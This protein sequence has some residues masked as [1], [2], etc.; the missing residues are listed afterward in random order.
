MMRWGDVFMGAAG[1]G[2]Q[3]NMDW[4]ESG[5]AGLKYLSYYTDNG[6]YY[7][8]HTTQGTCGDRDGTPGHG[9]VKN[10]M[11]QGATGYVATLD[12]LSKYFN[13]AV[14]AAAGHSR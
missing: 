4:T 10:T 5:D 11:P 1:A 13:E 8:Y 2:K 7:Y 14:S 9:C 12:A 6:A 3:R